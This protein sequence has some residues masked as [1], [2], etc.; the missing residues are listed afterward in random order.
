LTLQVHTCN[1]LP[2]NTTKNPRSQ[3]IET[4]KMRG[5]DRKHLG[6]NR[7]ETANDLYPDDTEL[8]NAFKAGWNR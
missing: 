4:A 8:A 2:M 1:V 3:Q 6:G 7:D 5:A